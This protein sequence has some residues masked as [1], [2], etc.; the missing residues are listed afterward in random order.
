VRRLP[1]VLAGLVGRRPLV[2]LIGLGLA[3][4]GLAAAIPQLR[5]DP[6][7]RSLVAALEGHQATEAR[8]AERFGEVG[9]VVLLM[10]SSERLL[11]EES[12][13]YVHALSTGLEEALG[14]RV[15]ARVLGPTTTPLARRGGPDGARDAEETGL[16]LDDL[17]AGGDGDGGG[18]TLDDLDAPAEAADELTLDDLGSEGDGDDGPPGIED[19]DPETLDAVGGIVR[20]EPARFPMGLASLSNAAAEIDRGPL[21]APEAEVGPE[22]VARAR[23]AFDGPTLLDR[24][25]ISPDRT[26]AGVAVFLSEAVDDFPAERKA[27]AAIQGWL[28]DHP[29]PD[30]AEVQLA[31]LPYL[32]V[33]IVEKM[34]ADQARLIPLTVLIC[35]VVLWLSFRWLPAVALSLAAV[36]ATTAWVL[37]GM[38]IVG[39]KITL[40]NN[41]LPAL[42]II[43]GISYSIHL[44]GRY[45]EQLRRGQ[46]RDQAIRTTVLAMAVGIFLTAATTAVGLGSLVVAR[47]GM[48]RRLGLTASLGVLA[49]FLI[50]VLLLP[51]A[52]R[53]LRA[54]RWERGFTVASTTGEATGEP[55][56]D[57]QQGGG[58]GFL[59]AVAVRLFRFGLDRRGLVVGLAVLLFAGSV[60]AASQLRVDSA[61]LDQFDPADPAYQATR[62]QEDKL[63]GVRPLEVMLSLRRDDGAQASATE[64]AGEAP[65]GTADGPTFVDAERLAALDRVADWAEGR[66]EVI[67]TT[68]PSD[69]LHGLWRLLTGDPEVLDQAFVDDDQVRGLVRLL[70]QREDGPLD[71]YLAENGRV[72]R[73]ELRLRDVGARASLRFFED[74]EEAIDRELRPALQDDGLALGVEMTGEAYVGSLVVSTVVGDM[75]GSLGTAVVIIFGFIMVLLRSPRLGLLAMPP[76]ILPLTL[77]MAWMILR[78]IPLNAATA[79]T[80]SVSLGMA[81]DGSIHLLARF[82]EERASGRSVDD[83]LLRAARGTGRAVVVSNLTLMAGF[84]VLVWSGFVPIRRFGELIAVT[85]AATTF[86]TLVLLPA[87]LRLGSPGGDPAGRRDA[88]SSV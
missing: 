70:R 54:R 88:P 41:I 3:T 4:A 53:F 32:H 80:F 60:A 37:G 50:T 45:R 84:A 10:V 51:S 82:R 57:G 27:V 12:L 64:G 48:I 2:V 63:A 20:A 85:I 7:P 17:D 72:A 62:L 23:A 77:A 74:L 81:V 44:L 15:V 36:L 68:S 76:N 13:G 67:T 31:G 22:D 24:R 19:L 55:G 71:R 38:A 83:C 21:V 25:L 87:L 26:V 14:D 58:G 56:D 78:G 30:G 16:T 42:L 6:S 28:D 43:I 73:L 47:S 69:F 39:E 49:A 46:D 5:A 86:T 29:P 9:R 8:F 34:V 35:L 79:I 65:I 66:D 18:L 52:L 40:L 59:E 11:T 61:V 75:L 33:S 1:S